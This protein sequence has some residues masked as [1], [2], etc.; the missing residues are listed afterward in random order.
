MMLQARLAN[1]A[2]SY[3][4]RCYC[5]SKERAEVGSLGPHAAVQRCT[6]S[7]QQLGSSTGGQHVHAGPRP[8]V[9][10]VSGLEPLSIESA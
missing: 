10:H 4:L 2:Q 9:A 1:V 7:C 5:K 6:A 3:L 8:R